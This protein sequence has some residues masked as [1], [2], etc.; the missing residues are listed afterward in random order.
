[1]ETVTT[2]VSASW[3]MVGA[4]RS[5]QAHRNLAL[6]TGLSK[7]RFSRWCQRHPVSSRVWRRLS[8]ERHARNPV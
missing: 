7:G 6:S 2:A 4:D 8:L 5:W 1:M 3:P